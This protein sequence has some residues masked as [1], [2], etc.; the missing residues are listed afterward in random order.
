[1]SFK[2]FPCNCASRHFNGIALDMFRKK[3]VLMVS[4][5]IPHLLRVAIIITFLWRFFSQD[6]F[7]L[8]MLRLHWILPYIINSSSSPLILCKTS[9]LVVFLVQEFRVRPHFNL[10]IKS[11]SLH[12]IQRD[13]ENA[14]LELLLYASDLFYSNF[15]ISFVLWFSS[16]MFVSK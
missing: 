13:V 5:E 8:P 11:P 3:L 10:F 6:V 15:F 16:L 9:S 1:M 4:E 14:T 12:S 2:P 7:Q